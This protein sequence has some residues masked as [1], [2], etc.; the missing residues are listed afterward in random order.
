MRMYLEQL[1][2]NE[3]LRDEALDMIEQCERNAWEYR[4]QYSLYIDTETLGLYTTEQTCGSTFEPVSVWEG[5]DVCLYTAEHESDSLDDLWEGATIDECIEEAKE[6]GL[7][8]NELDCFIERSL[9][10]E[11]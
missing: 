9:I 7:F 10:Y 2:K 1:Q 5:K 3:E 11:D 4:L 8:E 6:N